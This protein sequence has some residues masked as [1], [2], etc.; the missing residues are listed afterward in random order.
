MSKSVW[1]VGGD[2][3]AYDIGYG[4]LDHVLASGRDVNILVLDTEVYSNTG[5]Q[6]FEV[7]PARRGREVRRRRQSRRQEGPGPDRHELRQRLCRQVAMGAQDEHTLRAL[8][9]A[10]SYDG[11]SLII[12]YSHCIAHGINMMT[13]SAPAAEARRRLRPV[14]ALPLRPAR[15][16]RGENPLHSIPPRA[17]EGGGLPA[18][19]NRFKMLTKS[20]PEEA[21]MLFAQAQKTPTPLAATMSSWPAATSRPATRAGRGRNRASASAWSPQPYTLDYRSL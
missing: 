10:E 1:I 18:A 6:M 11:P 15:A 7:H 14:A 20:N 21:K 3:W 5:G 13:A 19:E 12:A 16:E 9:E 17:E 8:L 2:G 4:G